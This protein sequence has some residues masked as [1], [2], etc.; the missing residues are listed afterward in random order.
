VKLATVLGVS[1]AVLCSI[2]V[3][4]AHPHYHHQKRHVTQS[5]ARPDYDRVQMQN[6]P[7]VQPSVQYIAHPGFNWCGWWMRSYVGQ[8][9]G[10]PIGVTY[11][12]AREWAHFGRWAEGPA[13]GVIAVKPHHVMYVL[14]VPRL[15]R[16]VGIS[17]NDGHAVRVRERTTRGIIAWRR[18]E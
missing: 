8:K 3:A 11:N 4:D 5:V 14:S 1:L 10:Q 6:E 12:K 7:T 16:F 15:D 2:H 13:P 9:I 17:G 18:P